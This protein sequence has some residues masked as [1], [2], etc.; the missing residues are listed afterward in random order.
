MVDDVPEGYEYVKTVEVNLNEQDEFWKDPLTKLGMWQNKFVQTKGKGFKSDNPYVQ[1]IVGGLL[2]KLQE[3]GGPFMAEFTIA[4]QRIEQL[5]LRI[6]MIQAFDNYFR[7]LD[8]DKDKVITL[9]DLQSL[10]GHAAGIDDITDHEWYKEVADVSSGTITL[11]KWRAFIAKIAEMDYKQT[12][13][14][15]VTFRVCVQS[16]DVV[17]QAA[18][19]DDSAAWF[20]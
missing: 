6:Q 2:K 10:W 19:Y 3:R 9:D 16:A 20:S 7:I 12:E 5:N 1:S 13:A 8:Q 4:E 18:S 15:L 11:D 17:E 14:M